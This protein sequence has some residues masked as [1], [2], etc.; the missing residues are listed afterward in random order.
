MVQ[1]SP[2]HF[3]TGTFYW[4]HVRFSSE[5][6]NTPDN[7]NSMRKSV[8][9]TR[10]LHS[11]EGLT[12]VLEGLKSNRMWLIFASEQL[13]R[14]DTPQHIIVDEPELSEL[15]GDKTE[16]WPGVSS[17]IGCKLVL[18]ILRRQRL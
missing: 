15:S 6:M 5:N 11:W 9:L 16:V 3:Q 14:W 10:P 2:S 8:L 7:L 13:Q 12:Y 18:I 17:T 1:R 4:A